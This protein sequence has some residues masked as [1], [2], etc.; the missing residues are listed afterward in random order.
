MVA[1]G[2]GSVMCTVLY[3][4]GVCQVSMKSDFEELMLVRTILL[5]AI[6]GLLHGCV[7]SVDTRSS[8]EKLLGSWQS[9][10]GGFPLVTEYTETMVKVGNNDSVIYELSDNQLS[11]AQ[12]GS[13]KRI[14]S[15]P[16]KN[17]MIQ[18]DPLTNTRHEFVRIEQ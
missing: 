10:I 12:G 13:Q 8:H 9:N 6:F 4:T 15:F 16:K 3:H 2:P 11:F 5:A 18:V 7:T 1:N 17:L 14:L